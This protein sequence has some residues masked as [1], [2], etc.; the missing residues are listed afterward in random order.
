VYPPQGRNPSTTFAVGL[1]LSLVLSVLI[2]DRSQ[3][4]GF[5]RPMGIAPPRRA[6]PTRPPF[7]IRQ[8]VITTTAML[9][10]ISFW[11]AAAIVLNDLAS[12]AYYAGGI[13]EKAI[14]KAAP[15]FILAVMLFDVSCLGENTN[16]SGGCDFDQ[17]GGTG[18]ADK[19]GCRSGA[20]SDLKRPPQRTLAA[21]LITNTPRLQHFERCRPSGRRKRQVKFVEILLVQA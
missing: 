8:V 5:R 16:G 17:T 18:E 9:T 2:L 11:R 12:W 19:Q 13:A 3:A 14:G 4:C 20:L 1:R 15:W 21:P 10:F 7:P 6:G